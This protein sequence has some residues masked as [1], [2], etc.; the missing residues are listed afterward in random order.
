MVFD[1]LMFKGKNS[2]QVYI[3]KNTALQDRK[4]TLMKVVRPKKNWVEL[5]EYRAPYAD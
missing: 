5:V 2:P 1:I 3:F 4:E